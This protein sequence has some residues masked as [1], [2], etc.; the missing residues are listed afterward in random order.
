M[1]F[2][3]GVHNMSYSNNYEL[4]TATER[5]SLDFHEE[6]QSKTLLVIRR[7][8]ERDSSHTNIELIK[9]ELGI[10]YKVLGRIL[11]DLNLSGLIEFFVDSDKEG[12]FSP[13]DIQIEMTELGKDRARYT[14]EILEQQVKLL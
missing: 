14:Y 6:L 5:A 8:T 7:L 9:R 10:N 12:N 13:S 4:R 2:G 3:K 1:D 11:S